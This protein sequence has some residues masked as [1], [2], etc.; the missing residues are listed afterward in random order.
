MTDISVAKPTMGFSPSRATIAAAAAL[1]ELQVLGRDRGDEVDLVDQLALEPR[2]LG[3]VQSH[4]LA[5]EE[6]RLAVG[7]LL[8]NAFRVISRDEEASVT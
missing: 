3:G 5:A 4:R 8:A 1:V 2:H 7:D 6:L